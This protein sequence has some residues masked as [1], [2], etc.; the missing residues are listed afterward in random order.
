MRIC[1]TTHTHTHIHNLF[2]SFPF[3]FCLVHYKQKQSTHKTCPSRR[4]TQWTFAKA[5]HSVICTYI[6]TLLG[7]C[8]YVWSRCYQAFG[9]V[10]RK[11]NIFSLLLPFGDFFNS[12]CVC[13]NAS[14]R[15]V[16]FVAHVFPSYSAS[17]RSHWLKLQRSKELPVCCT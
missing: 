3:T 6:H 16:L 13:F 12:F 15:F 8:V 1:Q 14:F 11:A 4:I 10:I 5:L 7:V 2:V 17:W 9:S